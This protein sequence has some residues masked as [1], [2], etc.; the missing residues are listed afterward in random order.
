VTWRNF[1]IFSPDLKLQ[2]GLIRVKIYEA[3]HLGRFLPFSVQVSS[4]KSAPEFSV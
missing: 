4:F 3:A 2:I 1:E